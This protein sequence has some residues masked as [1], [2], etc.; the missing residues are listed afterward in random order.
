MAELIVAALRNWKRDFG[1]APR[2]RH[3]FAFP[4]IPV[5]YLPL[6]EASLSNTSQRKGEY[7]IVYTWDIAY[8]YSPRE[9]YLSMQRRAFQ[10]Q[11]AGVSGKVS[12]DYLRQDISTNYE[13]I[14]W[15]GLLL[16]QYFKSSVSKMMQYRSGFITN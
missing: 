8:S 3:L 7:H 12:N 10:S 1:Q 15:R 2:Q 9:S 6:I 5:H 16:I 4:G 11:F 14:R 13:Q